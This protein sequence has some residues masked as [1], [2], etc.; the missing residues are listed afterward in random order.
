L[1]SG[2]VTDED[3]V[4]AGV[5]LTGVDFELALGHARASFS[6]SIGA[7]KVIGPLLSIVLFTKPW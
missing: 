5:Q 7:P 6:D 4:R 1:I 2:S 3:L